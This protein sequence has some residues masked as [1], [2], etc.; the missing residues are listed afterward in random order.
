MNQRTGNPFP[1]K[2]PCH[3][4]VH[5]LL[6]IQPFWST[7][8]CCSCQTTKRPIA[9]PIFDIATIWE[10]LNDTT[11]VYMYYFKPI[12]HLKVGF[13]HLKVDLGCVLAARQKICSHFTCPW[14]SSWNDFVLLLAFFINN[15]PEEE[16]NNI[17]FCIAYIIME[18][19]M[20]LLMYILH[21]QN[22]LTLAM[23]SSYKKT[24]LLEHDKCYHIPRC[25]GINTVKNE[26]MGQTPHKH[27]SFV[28]KK[29]CSLNPVTPIPKSAWI[30]IWQCSW[31]KQF[32]LLGGF[33]SRTRQ[34]T[35]P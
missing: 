8:V 16:L 35:S 6:Y 2:R 28:R 23:S 15:C 20:I 27:Q 18:I 24:T 13:V 5:H 10:S 26:W 4:Q 31:L 21:W 14:A 30:G 17:I 1:I 32:S 9:N 7:L 25:H 3:L 22:I 12:I 29:S 19:C 33:P 34:G 11:S